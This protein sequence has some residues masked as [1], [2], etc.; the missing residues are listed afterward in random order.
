MDAHGGP[1][2]GKAPGQLHHRLVGLPVCSDRHHAAHPGPVRPLQH[3][4][5]I[6]RVVGEMQ[7]GVGVEEPHHT[8]MIAQGVTVKRRRPMSWPEAVITSTW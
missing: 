4:V 5:E 7:V 6:V 1:H 3:G 2:V 8:L